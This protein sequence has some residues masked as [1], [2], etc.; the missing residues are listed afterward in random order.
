MKNG[1]KG[2]NFKSLSLVA[3]AGKVLLKI[4][5]RQ[6]SDYSDLVGILSEDKFVSELTVVLWT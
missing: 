1:T 4:I 5:A 3:H 6:V 2:G